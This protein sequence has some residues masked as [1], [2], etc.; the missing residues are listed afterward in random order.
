M[1]G[2]MRHYFYYEALFEALFLKSEALCEALF[3]KSEALCEAFKNFLVI[4]NLREP[5]GFR[6][7]RDSLR[8]HFFFHLEGP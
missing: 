2:I 3:L 1:V 5:R 4:Q 8:R 6:P 7:F